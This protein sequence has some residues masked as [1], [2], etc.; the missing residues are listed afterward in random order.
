MRQYQSE[1]TLLNTEEREE[2]H[3]RDT[4]NELR[5]NVR[6]I[7]QVKEY[8]LKP[9]A[10]VRHS[11]TA[12]YRDNSRYD[13]CDRRDLEC[14]QKRLEELSSVTSAEEVRVVSKRKAAPDI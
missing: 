4:R 2:E 13:R 10:Q 11:E 8:A 1:L 12:E 14:R 9:L 6:H 5:H 3:E 7:R